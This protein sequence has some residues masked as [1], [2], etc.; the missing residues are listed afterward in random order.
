ML[1]LCGALA[2]LRASVVVDEFP[3][4]FINVSI[5]VIAVIAARRFVPYG[6]PEVGATRGLGVC[7]AV[8]VSGG[9]IALVYGDRHHSR[10]G[11]PRKC[12]RVVGPHAAVL[13][14]CENVVAREGNSTKE[15]VCG[16]ECSRFWGPDG[17]RS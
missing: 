2:E 4:L 12:G 15:Q 14:G 13:M 17:W 5:G 10:Q 7:G 11:R 1:H 3:V 9:L 16:A 6:R 8:T